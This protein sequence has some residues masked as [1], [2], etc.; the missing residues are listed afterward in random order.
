MRYALNGKATIGSDLIAWGHEA[1]RFLPHF[2]KKPFMTSS[3]IP[4]SPFVVRDL[5]KKV[6]KDTKRILELGPGL[7]TLTESLLETAGPN[8]QVIVIEKNP[9]MVEVLQVRFRETAL[10]I[11][12]AGAEDLDKMV[13][14][15]VDVVFS[16]IPFS[17]IPREIA[18]EIIRK[19]KEVLREGGQFVSFQNTKA[20]EH[21]MR[22]VFDEVESNIH[23]VNIP[24]Q[25]ITTAT[26]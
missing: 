1:G 24:P 12:Q 2:L 17:V 3:V 8:A 10:E 22:T 11:H 15:E 7:G 9:E 5:C 25:R 21:Y 13:R 14:G 20:A 4:T 26:K 18:L 16:S 6:K 19:V 23:W